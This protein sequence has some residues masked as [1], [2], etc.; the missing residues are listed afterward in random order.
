D[1]VTLERWGRLWLHF[2]VGLLDGVLTGAACRLATAQQ[3]EQLVRANV[4]LAASQT[5]PTLRQA[6]RSMGEQLLGLAE[7]WPG[8]TVAGRQLQQV[9][10]GQEW[11]HAIVFGV[12]AAAAGASPLEAVTVF[13]HQA[14]LGVISAGVRAVPIGHTH[15][16]QILARL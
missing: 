5:V 3:F 1:A 16:Q 8:A 14:A 12:L 9:G 4:L 7:P 10:V 6:S 11:H 13:L 2:A 15:G